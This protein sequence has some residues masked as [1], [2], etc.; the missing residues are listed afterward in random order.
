MYYA[1]EL[2]QSIVVGK[3]LLASKLV[4]INSKIAI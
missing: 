3:K 2:P 4:Y 1:K